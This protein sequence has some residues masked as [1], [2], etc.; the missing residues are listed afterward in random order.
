[1]LKSEMENLAKRSKTNSIENKFNKFNEF[2]EI[3]NY[4]KAKGEAIKAFAK[5]L[6]LEQADKIIEGARQ[7]AINR[8]S[9]SEFWKYP[10]TWLNQQCW[11]DE[12]QSSSTTINKPPPKTNQEIWREESPENE[13]FYQLN[14]KN[15]YEEH[16]NSK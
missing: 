12:Y 3:Y 14:L 8:K 2:W 4:K 7:Y 5:S 11:Y 16:K 9:E 15:R 10:A 6:K 13:R 1:M